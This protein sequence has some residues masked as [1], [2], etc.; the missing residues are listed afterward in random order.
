MQSLEMLY[1]KF[2]G[3]FSKLPSIHIKYNFFFSFFFQWDVEKFVTASIL[4]LDKLCIFILNLSIMFL[5]PMDKLL[6]VKRFL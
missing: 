2:K 6:Y 4:V 1:T 5:L 3:R